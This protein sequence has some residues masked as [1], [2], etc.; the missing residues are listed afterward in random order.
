MEMTIEDRHEV[1]EDLIPDV[2]VYT[3][4]SGNT[5]DGSR[6]QL[7]V[8]AICNGSSLSEMEYIVTHDSSLISTKEI[9]CRHAKEAIRIYNAI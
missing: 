2:G 7:K 4:A 8:R 5:A 9:V 6:K 3:F 1:S